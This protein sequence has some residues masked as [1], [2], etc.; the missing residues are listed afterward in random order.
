MYAE[1]DL[2][3]QGLEALFTNSFCPPF[4]LLQRR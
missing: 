4:I 1:K 2:V 3:Y